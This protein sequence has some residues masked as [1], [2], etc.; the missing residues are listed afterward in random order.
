VKAFR[1]PEVT[2][3]L[4]LPDF[5]KIITWRWWGCQLYAPPTFNPRK[6]FWYSFLLQ[7]LID[8]RAK[9]RPEGLSQWNIRMIPFGN[10]TCDY[11]RERCYISIKNY[12]MSALILF[13]LNLFVICNLKNPLISVASYYYVAVTRNATLTIKYFDW[14]FAFIILDVKCILNSKFHSVAISEY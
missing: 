5:E 2:R 10:R 7:D 13:L 12:C 1:G 9:L 6:Y 11:I 8:P 4:G 3:R 14:I